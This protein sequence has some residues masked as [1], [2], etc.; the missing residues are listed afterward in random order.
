MIRHKNIGTKKFLPKNYQIKKYPTLKPD[1]TLPNHQM[2]YAKLSKVYENLI[3]EKQDYVK[4]AYIL[5]EKAITYLKNV[6][7]ETGNEIVDKEIATL[8]VET[9]NLANDAQGVL[10]AIGE[11]VVAI[12]D[13]QLAIEDTYSRKSLSGYDIKEQTKRLLGERK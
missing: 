3:D 11:L 6:H 7:P 2:S 1:E 5:I 8:S 4:K 9:S 13:S 10:T 12:K